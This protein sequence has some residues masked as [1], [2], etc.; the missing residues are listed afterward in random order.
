MIIQLILNNL[1]SQRT[2][3][4]LIKL[5]Y[6]FKIR[7]EFDLITSDTPQIHK[8]ITKIRLIIK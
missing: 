5:I 4:S 1:I 2:D 3:Y 7:E 8:D 6:R